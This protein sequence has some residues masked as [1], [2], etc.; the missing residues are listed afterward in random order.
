MNYLILIFLFFSGGLIVFQDFKTR[1]ISV[2]VLIAFTL[3]CL[4]LAF[5]NNSF[6]ELIENTLFCLS[7]IALAYLMLLLYFFI[8][9]QQFMF[10]LSFQFG[11]ADLWIILCIGISL[12]PVFQIYFYTL[13]FCLSLVAHLLFKPKNNN[14]PLAAY[15]CI[16]FCVYS[17]YDLFFEI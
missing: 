14:V 2:W 1:L 8:K 9:T 7:Y 11:A 12:E 6:N 17:F 10:N 4:A 5:K 16:G 15:L 13:V 3:V